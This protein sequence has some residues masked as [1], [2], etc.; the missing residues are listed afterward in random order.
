[1]GKERKRRAY[2]DAFAIRQVQ[3]LLLQV[4]NQVVDIMT[5][6][7]EFKLIK[8]RGQNFSTVLV[9]GSALSE[10]KVEVLHNLLDYK[11]IVNYRKV[12]AQ[13]ELSL[14][15]NKHVN[16]VLVDFGV[17]GFLRRQHIEGFYR[18]SGDLEEQFV[19]G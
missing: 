13:I 9:L 16:F 4:H 7:L 18:L 14:N 5:T 1:M 15:L 6:V 11:H 2:C 10:S 12:V 17:G 3:T 19:L 8:I